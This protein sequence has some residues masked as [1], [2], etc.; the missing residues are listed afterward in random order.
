MKKTKL[1][2]NCE[3]ELIAIQDDFI[4]RWLTIIDENSSYCKD[5]IAT[6]FKKTYNHSSDRLFQYREMIIMLKNTGI[7]TYNE[8][9]LLNFSVDLLFN[10]IH[11]K[12]IEAIN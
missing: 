7:L 10:T 12:Y 9:R 1:F 2:I 3:N 5:P 6:R 8:F 4:L 11:R